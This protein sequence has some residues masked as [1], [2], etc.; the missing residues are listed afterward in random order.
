MPFVSLYWYLSEK[1]PYARDAV[2]TYYNRHKSAHTEEKRAQISAS[3]DSGAQNA[4]KFY[5]A[6]P[7]I[8]VVDE[9]GN[10][11]GMGYVDMYMRSVPQRDL[12]DRLMN[13][14]A[15]AKVLSEDL[16][17]VRDILI[18]TAFCLAL[19]AVYLFIRC[20]T[21][22]TIPTAASAALIKKY[23]HH[24]RKAFFFG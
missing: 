3:P 2:I 20:Y 6:F 8:V 12:M 10:P 1:Y 15:S 14:I 16:E 5:S 13:E 7:R 4:Q 19:R 9:Y 21:L 11:T 22:P 18:F 23:S 17:Y 24:P